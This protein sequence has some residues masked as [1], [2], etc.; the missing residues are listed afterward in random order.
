M[1]K[2]TKARYHKF[3]RA[4]FI[5]L[6]VCLFSVISGMVMPSFSNEK[7]KDLIKHLDASKIRADILNQESI[8]KDLKRNP[9]DE[10][11]GPG[12]KEYIS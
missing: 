1:M 12:L 3:I 8:H 4:I 10:K 7:V 9:G 6:T 2:N 11:M 5:V